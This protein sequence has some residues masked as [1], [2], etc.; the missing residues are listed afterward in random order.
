MADAAVALLAAK[1]KRTLQARRSDGDEKEEKPSR[2]SCAANHEPERMPSSAAAT[3]WLG[4]GHNNQDDQDA[5]ATLLLGLQHSPLKFCKLLIERQL[6]WFFESC[7]LVR[8]ENVPQESR[9]SA[10][11]FE[12]SG[13]LNVL[14]NNKLVGIERNHVQ[15]RRRVRSND[16]QWLE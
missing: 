9:H 8:G 3:N 13:S 16:L 11:T 10:L 6:A 4:A 7:K 1:R 14:C 12:L 15:L 5:A 2:R